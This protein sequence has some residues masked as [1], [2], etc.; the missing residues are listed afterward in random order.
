MAIPPSFDGHKRSPL[1]RFTVLDDDDRQ[2][3][4]DFFKRFAS[5]VSQATVPG[6]HGKLA[7][8]DDRR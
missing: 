7:A 1:P 4:Y 5:L 3:L 2:E 8:S 6:A